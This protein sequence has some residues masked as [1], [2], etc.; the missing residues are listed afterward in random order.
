MAV[1]TSPLQTASSTPV[2]LGMEASCWVVGDC[3]MVCVRFHSVRV[4]SLW[5]RG[6]VLKWSRVSS[7]AW[8]QMHLM[9]PVGTWIERRAYHRWYLLRRVSCSRASWSPVLCRCARRLSG[10]RAE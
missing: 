2:C 1:G 9:C 4:S 5:Y 8:P 3:G 6:H 7:P 10:R